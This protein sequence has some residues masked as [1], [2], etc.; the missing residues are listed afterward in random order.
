LATQLDR[1]I[2][3]RFCPIEITLQRVR[4]GDLPGRVHP[5]PRMPCDRLV[6]SHG[7]LRLA[8]RL[9]KV[10]EL[11]QKHGEVAGS[12]HLPR[13]LPR[14]ADGTNI[15]ALQKEIDSATV[16]TERVRPASRPH[17]RIGLHP[18]DAQ[19]PRDRHHVLREIRHRSQIL[20]EQAAH[21][22]DVQPRPAQPLTVLERL[23]ERLGL[24]EALEERSE[25][26]ERQECHVEV[27]AQIDRHL[28]CLPALRKAL[29]RLQR[30]LD[31]R[32]CFMVR[33]PSDRFHRGFPTIANSL[34][35]LS[36][37]K[38]VVSQAL[39]VL[40]QAVGLERLDRA[41]DLCVQ[42][43]P[44]LVQYAAIGDLVRQRVLER[45][46]EI[47]KQPCL[48]E[49][50]RGLQAGQPGPKILVVVIGDRVQERKRYVLAHHGRRL[51]QPLVVEW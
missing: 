20:G 14:L 34:V 35:P 45:V 28:A 4:P 25:L 13:R 19:T 18:L 26:V 27:E 17:V 5:T 42:R 23:G 36:A 16:L 1:L 33:R 6:R 48:V 29:E 2:G 30:L 9:G 43:T 11:G 49:E 39:G 21:M 37:T 7:D 47:R 12:P 15:D 46:F 31:I 3:Q 51:E 40:G 8:L 10:T 41:D 44:S 24:A 38:R 22:A 50:L 32:R